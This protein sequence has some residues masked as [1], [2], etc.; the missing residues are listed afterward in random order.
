MCSS[1]LLL[2][3]QSLVSS[4]TPEADSLQAVALAAFE[5]QTPGDLDRAGEL[6]LDAAAAYEAVGD[7]GRA[8]EMLANAGYVHNIRG[9]FDAAF[10]SYGRALR[11]A[12]DAGD[13]SSEALAL[14]D[15][16]ELHHRLGQLDSAATHY[17]ESLVLAREVV[18]RNTEGRMLNNLGIVNN[19]MGVPDAA[20][21]Y[22]AEALELRQNLGDRVG[23]A[24]TLNNLAQVQLTVGRPDSAIA[25]Q[26]VSL[27]IRLEIGDRPAAGT[28]LNN[29]G[30]AFS[31]LQEP[32]SSLNYY[33]QALGIWREFERPGVLSLT[34]SNMGRAFRALG[35]L[36]SALVYTHEALAVAREFGDRA[37]EV[38]ALEDLGL[39]FHELERPDSALTAFFGGL[40]AARDV[41]D[42]AREGEI[43]FHLAR[44]HHRATPMASLESAVAYYDSAAAVRR[45]VAERAGVD[46]DRVSFAEQD[47][48]LFE[49]WAL[50]WLARD[51]VPD[52]TYAAL[53]AAERGRAQGLLDLM[54]SGAPAAGAAATPRGQTTR[55]TTSSEVN[56]STE[57][58][59][60]AESA[61]GTDGALLY[62]LA[63]EDTLLAWLIRPRQ[64]PLTS[65]AAVPLDSLA[66][67]VGYLRVGLGLD[68]T[69]VGS[70]IAALER[71][72]EVLGPPRRGADYAASVAGL[73][74]DILLPPPFAAE[75]A[76]A[77][78]V[79]IVPQ[80]PLG[81]LPFA[82]LPLGRRNRL[83]EPFGSTFAIRYAPSL[84]A[85]AE[86]SGRPAISRTDRGGAS[87]DSTP[88]SSALVVGDPSMPW[89]PGGDGTP[90]NLGQLPGSGEEARWVGS[91]LG[92]APLIG[93]EAT[94]AT[95]RAR[96][97]DAPLVHLA[98]HGYAYATEDRTRDSFV[99]LAPG[100]GHDGLLRV[101]E[102]FEDAEL[103][104]SAELVV[105][106]AC[107]TGLGDLKR[108]EGTIG[109]QRA[110]LARGARSVLVSLWSVSDVVTEEMMRA[111]Y[112]H[113][114]GDEDRPTKAEALYRAQ[115]DVS[116]L[117]GFEH[118]RFW[119]AFQLVG[120][121]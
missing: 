1:Q 53:A 110:L 16:G 45:S 97:R 3:E 83:L 71:S 87:R 99:A 58:R 22:L 59:E 76:G 93:P 84:G 107:Q 46:E 10:T 49:D 54:R 102:L 86:A 114:L 17:E 101:G 112:E 60:I 55:E 74:T 18:D 9:R 50:A 25:L 6:F 65:R 73:L 23:E 61:L 15:I 89:V 57:G 33:R 94:E 66:A 69:A 88:F 30:L 108:A 115:Q 72:P 24:V 98:T 119:A 34:L 19:D 118:P 11:L 67:W 42:R 39:T 96:L 40:D 95:V 63:T 116:R 5:A 32:D 38:W 44:L 78:E 82:V 105:L 64:E 80:G 37:S 77:R 117:A 79:V 20:G 43:L 91:F 13:R 47:V 7:R 68:D 62:Y 28:V 92:G 70:R 85:L 36:D 21:A 81:S 35:A 111:F 109:F 48:R 31:R 113:W 29:I 121:E 120:A 52:N 4:A 100:G 75:L 12:R 103:T 27:A 41:G 14:G 106:S 26:R 51:D 2:A 56:L 8:A 90:V 104:L